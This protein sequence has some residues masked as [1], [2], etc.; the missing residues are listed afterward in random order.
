MTQFL[1]IAE[2]AA[3]PAAESNDAARLTAL[4][5]VSAQRNSIIRLAAELPSID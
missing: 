3:P 2:A 4:G 5:T 1:R